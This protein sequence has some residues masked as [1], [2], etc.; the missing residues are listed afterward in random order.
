MR[1]LRKINSP[2]LWYLL[3][4]LALF[5]I[6]VASV[7]GWIHNP[8]E[9]FVPPAQSA[10][11]TYVLSEVQQQKLYLYERSLEEGLTYRQFATL[12]RIAE[13]ESH[14]EQDAYN[15]KTNDKGIFQINIVHWAKAQ[16]DTWQGN[17]DYALELYLEEGTGPWKSSRRCWN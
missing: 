8:I 5:F 2:Q 15:K 6:G 3:F 11:S 9:Y 17:I 7:R 10:S 4:W 16:E 14:W 13:C 12:W 1:K